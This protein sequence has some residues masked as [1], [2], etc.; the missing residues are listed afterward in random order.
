MNKSKRILLI[1]DED[2][3]LFG[4]S[5]VLKEP[6]IEVDCAQTLEEALACIKAHL[7]DAAIVDLRL[8][9][10][11]KLE[12]FDCVRQLRASQGA[13]RILMLTAY[14]DNAAWEKSEELE[15]DLFLEKPIDPAIIRKTLKTFGVYDN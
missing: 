4:F 8:T 12:G 14:G 13:C 9:N 6:G 2:V 7:Y 5:K 1:D 11:T 10:S 15:V 3:T